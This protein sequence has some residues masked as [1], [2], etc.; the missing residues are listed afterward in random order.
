MIN[1]VTSSFYILAGVE[2]TNG[3][4]DVYEIPLP[5]MPCRISTQLTQYIIVLFEIKPLNFAVSSGSPTM[6]KCPKQ[7]HGFSD[8]WKIGSGIVYDQRTA[9]AT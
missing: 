5:I 6:T 2:R 8:A 7:K 3:E 4:Q 1:V 9:G